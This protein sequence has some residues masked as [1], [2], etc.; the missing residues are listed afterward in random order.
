M[1]SRNYIWLILLPLVLVSC[2][3]RFEPNLPVEPQG[4]LV[5]EGFINAEGP[6]QIKLSRSTA[7]D[8]DQTLKA[9]LNAS[10]AIEGDDNSSFLLSGLAD[11]IYSAPALPI[12]PSQKYRLR[13]RTIDAK[14]YLSDF[15]EVKI[16]PAIDSVS[17]L[18]ENNG[19]QV[20]VNTHD[21]LN[22]TTY[23][24]WD[25]D[26]TWEIHSAYVASFKLDRIDPATGQRIIREINASD[27]PIYTCWKYDTATTILL[28]SSAKLENDIIYRQPIVFMPRMDERIGVR[29][30]I[31]VRQYALDKEGYEFMEQMKKNT[32]SLG[33]IFDP[34]P[35]A[36]RGNIR[37][38]SHPDEL[39][40]G[41]VHATTVAQVR[42]FLSRSQLAGQGFSIYSICESI[43]VPNNQDSL[44]LHIPNGWPYEGIYGNAGG[45]IIAYKVSSERCVDCTSRGG[46]NVRPSF[47]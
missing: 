37:C 4:Y 15:V 7:I 1:N 3:E 13:I 23:Y 26:E 39:V 45:G 9:E 27:P 31:Q 36:L 8:E 6:S 38:T 34:Q 41:Y 24:R 14:E 16:T 46:K 35:S 18:Q 22:K 44:R 32:E 10:I 43:D 19:V 25:Y 30:S 17:W 20:Y 11:G 21:P 2:K 33:T 47:W 40:I 12:N 28:G 42:M 29:Y 5:V